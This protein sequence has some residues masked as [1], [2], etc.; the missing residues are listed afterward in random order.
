M[1][2]KARKGKEKTKKMGNVLVFKD[3]DEIAEHALTLWTEIAEK[4]IKDKGIFSAALSGGK[5]P[6]VLFRKLSGNKTLPWSK[7]HIFMVD[8]RFVPYQDDNN[9]F[10]MIN[11]MLLRHVD[12]P[13]KNIHPILTTAESPEAA[14]LKYEEDLDYF[15]R[16]SAA[17]DLVLLGIGSDGH[18]A[19]LFP[20]MPTLKEKQHR[21][22]A[23]PP[24]GPID[25]ERITLT[26]PAIN[27]AENILFMA[28]GHDKARVIREVI[29]KEN[30]RLPAAAVRPGKCRPV[31]LL[32]EGAASLL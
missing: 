28:A 22:I 8:E 26:F 2:M 9:N 6:E 7:T 16:S 1:V 15:F 29:E 13:A 3:I 11:E 12:I 19:S 18:T 21:A 27:S 10:R 5:T 4:A 30:S 20:G 31:F 17:F 23:V 24:A 25:A 14:A 32:D